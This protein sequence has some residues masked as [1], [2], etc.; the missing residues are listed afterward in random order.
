MKTGVALGGGGVRGL[1]HVLALETIDGC[2][3]SP[4]ALAGTSMGAIIGALYAS[5]RS[6]KDIRELVERHMVF[7]GDGIREIYRKKEALLKVLTAL[8]PAW[9]KSGL[10]RADGFLHYLLDEIQADTFEDLKIPLRVVATDF[11]R[12]EAVVFDSGPILPAIKASMSIPGIFVPVEHEGRIL[13]DGGLVNNLPYDLLAGE[14]DATIAVD[15]APTREPDE[16]GAPNIIDATLG[17]FDILVERVV[18]RGLEDRPPTVYVHPK[19]VNIRT[20][21]FEKIKVVFE[22]ARPAMAPFKA[23]LEKALKDYG[24]DR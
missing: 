3:I 24:L 7:R 17:M 22:Q 6:G 15:V 10:L 11:Y 20:L 5:G 19:L 14:C 1:A 2:G 4:K 18:A 12:G 8:R 13:V 9:K 23:A 21:D 16:S